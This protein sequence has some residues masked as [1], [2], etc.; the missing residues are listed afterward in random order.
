MIVSFRDKRTGEFAEGTRI[1][2]FAG[3]KRKAEMKLNQLEV[4]TS[5]F[6]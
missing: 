6:D 1:K 5:L 2:A 4:A 3:F